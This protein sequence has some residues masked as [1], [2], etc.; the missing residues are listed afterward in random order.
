MN[1]IKISKDCY[2]PKDNVSF[3][4]SYQGNVIKR[5]VQ[6]AKSK[7]KIFD[8]TYG[9]KTESVIFLKDG[10]LILTNTSLDTLKKRMDPEPE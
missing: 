1:D 7:G 10:I 2:V 3:Y 6:S 8:C 9:H 5:E 4:V